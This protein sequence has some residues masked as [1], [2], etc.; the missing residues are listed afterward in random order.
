MK[1]FCLL[2]SFF[3]LTFL[4]NAQQDLIKTTDGEEIN[5]FITREDSLKVYFK[6]GSINSNV[7]AFVNKSKVKEIVYFKKKEDEQAP[8]F[9][10]NPAQAV[11]DKQT[12]DTTVQESYVEIK[13][14]PEK[15]LNAIGLQFGLAMPTGNFANSSDTNVIGDAMPGYLINLQFNHGFTNGLNIQLN[16]GY[17]QFA[18]NTDKLVQRYSANTD[19]V[20]TAQ[21]G[22]YTAYAAD[23]AIGYCKFFNDFYVRGNLHVGFI[24]MNIPK[25]KYGVSSSRFLEYQTV[26]ADAVSFG[27][28]VSFGYYIFESIS[29]D[30]NIYYKQSNVLYREVLIFG[31]EPTATTPNKLT[32]TRR[33][34]KLP[35]KSLGFS[36]GFN[37]WF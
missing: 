27:G 20:W 34:V 36:L 26:S 2:I 13:P 19:S 24:S 37:F 7:E 4:S 5:C 3:L 28:S 14:K 32:Y 1:R 30:L 23:A 18:I 35:Y 31:E 29:V 33:D 21:G 16:A 25:L 15:K 17:S 8:I 6:V 22:N 10:I 11:E 12:T 9:T